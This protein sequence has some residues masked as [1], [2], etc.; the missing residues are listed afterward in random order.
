MVF[1]NISFIK[2]DITFCEGFSD[3]NTAPLFR[4]KFIINNLGCA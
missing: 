4:K 1:E 2:P 3:R